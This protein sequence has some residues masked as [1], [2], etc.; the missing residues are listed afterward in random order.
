MR[1]QS[2]CSGA[3]LLVAGLAF[4]SHPSLC[5]AQEG[6]DPDLKAYRAYTLTMPKYK[7]YLAAM[8]DVARAAE[9]KPA[10][11]QAF[12]D[13]GELSIADAV[14]RFDKVPEIRRA[15]SGAGFT[16]REFVVAQGALL[17]AALSHQL[18]KQGGLTPDSVLKITEGSRTN[19][20]F[21]SKNEPEITR[22]TM[23]AEAK[24]PSLKHLKG[25]EEEESGAAESE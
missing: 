8:V 19:L 15:I 14:A 16:T 1:A 5:S 12:E 17:E 7:K 23:E 25:V 2:W 21:Y 9:R 11:N 24:A 18:G 3:L 13:F 4:L 6:N 20:E 22:L 10:V